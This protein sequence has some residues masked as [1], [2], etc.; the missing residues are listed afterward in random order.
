M[1]FFDIS[2]MKYLFQFTM[3]FLWDMHL[4]A[5]YLSHMKF[6]EPLR[7]AHSIPAHDQHS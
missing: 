4:L 2:V 3:I 5:R 1:H 7:A 6:L